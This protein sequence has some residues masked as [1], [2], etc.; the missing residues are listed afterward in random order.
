M[1]PFA[2]ATEA[3]GL[4]CCPTSAARNRAA[5]LVHLPGLP[6]HVFPAVGLAVDWP[7]AT[8]QLSQRLPLTA[9]CMKTAST[10]GQPKRFWPITMPAGQ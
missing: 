10:R 3:M 1:P 4:G 6:Q 2:L 8:L 7:T 5:E 9:P